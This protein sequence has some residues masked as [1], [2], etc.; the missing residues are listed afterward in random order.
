MA[1]G[2]IL[3]VGKPSVVRPGLLEAATTKR[4]EP[5]TNGPVRISVVGAVRERPSLKD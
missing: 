2:N 1:A 5:F 3:A 4:R